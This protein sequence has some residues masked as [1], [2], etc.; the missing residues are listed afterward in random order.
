MH[1]EWD[2]CPLAD[3]IYT[4]KGRISQMRLEY[5]AEI[6]PCCEA[7]LKAHPYETKG[8]LKDGAKWS[9]R[10]GTEFKGW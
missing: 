6:S 8:W 7:P 4:Y 5:T 9:S 10:W 2:D 3:F 1:L